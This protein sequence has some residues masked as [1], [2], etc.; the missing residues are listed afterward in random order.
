MM[1]MRNS[2]AK[3]STNTSFVTLFV[4]ELTLFQELALSFCQT[5]SKVAFL[6]IAN[7]FTKTILSM[8]SLLHWWQYRILKTK[9]Q[10]K[11]VQYKEK[12]AK[13]WNRMKSKLAS[14]QVNLAFTWQKKTLT[15]CFSLFIT[16]QMVWQSNFGK[17]STALRKMGGTCLHWRMSYQ[18]P[19][20]RNMHCLGSSRNAFTAKINFHSMKQ[21]ADSASFVILKCTC[22][23]LPNWSNV[24][25]LA[26][27][28]LSSLT[29]FQLKKGTSKLLMSDVLIC[30]NPN[31]KESNY[32]CQIPNWQISTHTKMN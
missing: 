29:T 30:S 31:T 27:L 18:L 17:W 21:C 4:Q 6:K 23:V 9:R 26:L 5:N 1:R 25:V 15:P 20:D 22:I 12:V 11:S 10:L 24:F 3:I 32:F 14:Q 19:K 2:W 28:W 16:C 13:R 8:Q 7:N